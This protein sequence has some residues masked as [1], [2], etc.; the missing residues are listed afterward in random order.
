VSDFAPDVSLPV[1][2]KD[3]A[4]NFGETGL[5]V[6]QDSTEIV[7]G[8]IQLANPA[9]NTVSRPTDDTTFNDE[10]EAGLVINPNTAAGGV[11][12]AVSANTVP[13][14][15]ETAYLERVSDGQMIDTADVSGASAGD[16]VEL[17]GSLSA[18]TD[19]AVYLY[20]GGTSRDTGY[21][22]NPTYPYEDAD[23]DIVDGWFD[24]SADSAYARCLNDIQLLGAL[25][26]VVITEWDTPGDPPDDVVGWDIAFYTV[27][28]D[29]E[30][31]DV[32]IEE[33]QGSPGWTEIA[34]PVT[35][36]DS[37]PADKANDVRFRIELSR[38]DTANIPTLDSIGRRWKL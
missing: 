11:E 28:R 25:D 30:T 19:Y 17:R 8:S 10:A 2:D 7:D 36:G 5:S 38:S 27:T 33:A 12:V 26:G 13:G 6:T 35:D 31:V 18:G 4:R 22:S 9:G 3:I 1:A 14:G 15:S 21:N 24:G 32:F 29:S 34:G 16:R 20:A 23:V 37:I